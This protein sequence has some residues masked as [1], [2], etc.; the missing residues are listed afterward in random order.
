MGKAGDDA[1][2]IRLLRRRIF[3]WYKK[4]GRHDLPWRKTRDPYKILVSEIMLQQTQVD[5]VKQKYLSF[6]QKFPDAQ[7]LAS[8][9]T[10]DVIRAWQGL[11]YNR[12]ALNLQKAAQKV[13]SDF[14]GRLPD[15]TEELLTL[16]GIGPYTAESVKAFAFHK[17]TAAL[18]VNI[19]RIIHRWFFGSDIPRQKASEQQLVALA[20]ACVP[21][22][23]AFDWNSALMDFGSGI[24]KARRPLCKICPVKEY[25]RAYPAILKAQPI[26]QKRRE[27]SPLSTPSI[28]NRIYR[29]RIV[30][31]LRTHPRVT[32]KKLGPLIKKDFS[33]VDDSEWL[34]A[35]VR[36]LERDG[37]IVL[38]KNIAR[39]P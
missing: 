36:N 18:D 26:K 34:L 32:I 15:T 19:R 5:K 29:G 4:N 13:V 39:L 33:E 10:Q 38:Q 30:E 37:L 22:A 23:K 2:K 6:L 25:C 17:P 9:P 21:R 14:H 8:A 27:P 11:G 7:T 20:L 31:Y 24:C 28:P 1:I 35:L 12:R 16:P 3:A